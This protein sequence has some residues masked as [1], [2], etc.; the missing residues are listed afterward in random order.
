MRMFRI[1]A[2]VVG[3]GMVL[4]GCSGGGDSTPTARPSSVPATATAT[5]LAPAATS[6][7][8]SPPTT[9]ATPG[10]SL[11]VEVGQLLMAG[12]DGL[13]A[14]DDAAHVIRELHVGNV[15]LMGRN[16]QSKEQVRALTEQLSK[17]ATEANGVAPLIGTDQEGGTVQRLG[18]DAGFA[19][20]PEAMTMGTWSEAQVRAEGK[21]AGDELRTAG[22]NL[23]F[24]PDLDVNDNPDNPVIGTRAFG[25]TPEVVVTKAPAFEQ[26]LRDAGVIGV[27]KHF[28]GHGNTETNSHY[29]LPVVTKSRAQLEAVELPPFVAAIKAGFDALMVAHVAYPVLD[30]SGLPATVS[31]PIV[32]DL[33]RGELGFRGVVFT[34]D[35]GMKGLSDLM[36]PEEAAVRAVNAGADILLCVRMEQE[37]SC[38]HAMLE[39]LRNGLLAAVKDGR[40]SRERLDESYDRV[41]RLKNSRLTT[42][43]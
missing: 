12:V 2:A 19:K 43:N 11:E 5:T 13:T 39:R 36:A 33:L 4:G 6:T 14:S 1:A 18:P 22:V 37:G 38:S 35:M 25:T 3:V 41:L 31:K 17:M 27:G 16:V 23:D 26:G 32:T 40:I 24:A 15:I 30:P 42:H 21:L 34:D 10:V 20:L 28:P 9:T 8:A 29:A 7:P